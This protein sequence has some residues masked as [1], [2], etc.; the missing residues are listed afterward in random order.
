M[1]YY[2]E[3]LF[4]WQD[5]F[6]ELTERVVTTAKYAWSVHGETFFVIPTTRGGGVNYPK[7]KCAPG[8]KRTHNLP[9]KESN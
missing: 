1:V 3:V 7:Q 8:H 2:G 6:F 4:D 5:K 9:L